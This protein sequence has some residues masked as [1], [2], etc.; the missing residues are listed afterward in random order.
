M[1]IYRERGVVASRQTGKEKSQFPCR[2]LTRVLQTLRER[3]ALGK[4]TLYILINLITKK[5]FFIF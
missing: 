2:A 1:L 3:K 5:L 4:T